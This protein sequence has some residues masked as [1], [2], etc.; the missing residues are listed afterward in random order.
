HGG[1]AAG[2]IRHWQ[3]LRSTCRM[4][5]STN[6]WSVFDGRPPVLGGGKNRA[7]TAYC[8]SDNRAPR[9]NSPTFARVSTVQT[10]CRP[11]SSRPTQ[12]QT[13]SEPRKLSKRPLRPL[14]TH[15]LGLDV[16]TP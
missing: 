8:G 16:A 15:L 11:P 3:P 9:P 4:P 12:N 14:E 1:K 5:S 7:K 10:I 2:S 6:R 13:A